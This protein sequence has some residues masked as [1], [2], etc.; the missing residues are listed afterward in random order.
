MSEENVPAS[1]YVSPSKRADVPTGVR[2]TKLVPVQR[3]P[4]AG[5]V[6]RGS[7]TIESEMQRRGA[8]RNWIT[9]RELEVIRL[10]AQGLEEKEVATKL[11]LSPLTIKSHAARCFRKTKVHTK[12]ELVVWALRKGL[13]YSVPKTGRQDPI[14]DMTGRELEMVRLTIL[15]LTNGEM[16]KRVFLSE[17]T[18]KTHLRKVFKKTGAKNR[19]HLVTI[20]WQRQLVPREAFQEEE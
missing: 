13:L 3:K 2:E 4:A 17:D 9:S 16:G 14:P 20:A 10:V 8:Q 7:T 11:G 12:V 1:A 19:A 5:Y 18:I 6:Y 15:G